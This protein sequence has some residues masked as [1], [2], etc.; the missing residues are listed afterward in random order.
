[1]SQ[2][3]KTKYKQSCVAAKKVDSSKWLAVKDAR[4]PKKKEDNKS[5]VA[6]KKWTL[7]NHF[8]G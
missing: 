2:K 6:V 3:R 7:L 1:M 8:N 5:R 4:E